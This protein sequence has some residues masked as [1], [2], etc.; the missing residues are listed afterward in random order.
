MLQR[1]VNKNIQQKV[2]KFIDYME[3]KEEERPDQGLEI[4]GLISVKLRQEVF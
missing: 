2:V 1:N 3:Q 4:L